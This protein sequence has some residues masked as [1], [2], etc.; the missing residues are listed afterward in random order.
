MECADILPPKGTVCACLLLV[1]VVVVVAAVVVVVVVVGVVVVVVV[2]GVGSGYVRD[3]TFLWQWKG[4]SAVNTGTPGLY[5]APVHLHPNLAFI[6]LTCFQHAQVEM[7]ASLILAPVEVRD[8]ANL[9]IR[10]K[11]ELQALDSWGVRWTSGGMINLIRTPHTLALM[12]CT[13]D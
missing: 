11:S 2:V 8:E 12:A 7:S 1:V 10:I 6:A 9:W 3:G 5:M 4:R 13:L